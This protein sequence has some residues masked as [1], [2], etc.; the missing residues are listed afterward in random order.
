MP[1]Y[2]SRA[3]TPTTNQPGLLDYISQGWDSLLDT[4]SPFLSPNHPAA[5]ASRNIDW[6]NPDPEY[7]ESPEVNEQIDVIG[8]SVGVDPSGFG[9]LLGTVKK[10][11]PKYYQHKLIRNKKDV[12]KIKKEG[13]KPGIGMNVI[14]VFKGGKPQ[15]VVDLKYG[16]R[17]GDIIMLVPEDQ[18]LN[19]NSRAGG[20]PPMVKKGF[21]PKEHEIV[22]IEYDWQSPLEAQQ[23]KIIKKHPLSDNLPDHQNYKYWNKA[24]KDEIKTEA[25]YSFEYRNLGGLL[26]KS[27]LKATI[28]ELKKNGWKVTHTSKHKD[29]VSSYYIN[30]GG[31]D[32]PTIRVSDHE[33]PSTPERLHNR[34]NTGKVGWDEEI[35]VSGKSSIDEIKDKVKNFEE[36]FN[37]I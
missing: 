3:V 34:Q 33:L 10:K 2:G 23:K 9:G 18:V 35:I 6:D 11:F 24:E 1:S 8:S 17:K 13:F 37:D 26:K 27:N 22:E 32:G 25:N 36:W 14:P 21:K 30:K 29:R 12:E 16:P 4:G 31:F 19:V 15:D 5:I 20:P 28:R 7:W